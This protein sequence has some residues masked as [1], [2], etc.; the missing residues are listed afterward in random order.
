MRYS[1]SWAVGLLFFTSYVLISCTTPSSKAA[2]DQTTPQE[3][4]YVEP[5][6]DDIL[7]KEEQEGYKPQEV[8]AALKEGNQRFVN[9][10]LTRRDHSA[11]IRQTADAQYPKAIVLACVD[12]RVPVEDVFD[13][14]IG[15]IFVA[16][17]AGNVVNEDIL[18]S[19]EYACKVAGS[20][21]IVVLGHEHCGAV[22]SAVKGV[23][24]GN[25]TTLLSK[26]KPAI[27]ATDYAGERNADNPTFVHE[28][29]ETNI[30]HSINEIR[31]RSE[32][33]KEME[34]KGDIQIVGAIYDMH[35]GKVA[36]Q[37]D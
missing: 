24:L 7:T 30:Q 22:H 28:V 33:L 3:N 19:M 23:E 2:P 15:D 17:V 4:A 9:N 1:I 18:G 6:D 27:E 37:E 8:I 16:R 31:T 34:A 21:L 13:R 26:I 10:D 36:F 35:T 14:G 32:I 20:K 11:E 25:I 12:S 5:I 29:T